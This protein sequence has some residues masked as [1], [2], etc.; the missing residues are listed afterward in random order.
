MGEEDVFLEDRFSFDEVLQVL[1]G[2]NFK[3]VYLSLEIFGYV[4]KM[5]GTTLE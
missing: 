5:R 4:T 1:S 2:Y 3:I